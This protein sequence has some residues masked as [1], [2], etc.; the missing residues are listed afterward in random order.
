MRRVH[1]SMTMMVAALSVLTWTAV[2]A[3]VQGTLEKIKATRTITIGHRDSSRPFSFLGDD[4]KPAG[5]SVDLCVRIATGVQQELG[6][7]DLAIKWVKVTPENRLAMVANG[8]VDIE[9]G[10][11]TTTLSRQEQVDFTNM[12]F[13]DGG[14]FLATEASG[15]N[16]VSD[17]NGKRVAVIPGTTTE[18]ALTEAVAK[19]AVTP[20]IIKVPDHA[21]GLAALERGQ[22]DAYASDR[23]LLI[24]LGRTLRDTSKINVST[25]YFSYEPYALMVRRGDSSF[26]LAA[27]RTLARLYRSGEILRIYEKWFGDMGHPSTLLLAMYLLHSVPE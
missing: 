4:G 17:L 5:Y 16:V 10:S 19:A 7:P 26:R 21:Q 18:K 9:C 3:E 12:T 8:T 24:G 13:V 6:L 11:T 20:Q 15:I 14:S 25:E 1:G 27:N 2:A 23:V 22:A